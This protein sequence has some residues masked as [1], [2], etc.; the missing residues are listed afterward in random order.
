MELNDQVYDQIVKLCNEGNA[1]VE[2]G[3]DDKAIEIFRAALD[4]VPLPK[5]DWEAS[6]WI[7]TALGDTYFLNGD[8]EKAKSNLY[9][10]LNCP[11]GTSNPFILLRLGESLFEC[12][13]IDKAKEYLLR[14]YILEGYKIF[15][16][17]DDKYFE[18]IKDII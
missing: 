4:L 8:Y 1:F 7:Y 10:A 13:E 12:G 15:F 18:L 5:S 3:K 11:E 6:T 14:A 9:N 16:N 17:E 2:Q